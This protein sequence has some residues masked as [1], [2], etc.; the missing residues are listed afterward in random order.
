[1][2]VKYI[3]FDFFDTLAFLSKAVNWDNVFEM[4]PTLYKEK[5]KRIIK[6]NWI[7]L[8]MELQS[9]AEKTHIE[10]SMEDVSKN[11]FQ[12][13]PQYL[14]ED[15]FHITQSYMELW[16]QSIIVYQDVLEIIPKLAQ[17]YQLGIISNTHDSDVVPSIINRYGLAKYFKQIVLSVDETYR[18][19]NK[20]IFQV[21]TG[22]F[23]CP[24]EWCFIGDNFEQDIQ[25]AMA[26]NIFPI[27]ISR[28]ATR[29]RE[30]CITINTLYEIGNVLNIGE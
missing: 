1:M 13:I 23:H 18:K 16:E 6:T 14:E 27:L 9:N 4:T 2:N 19:P 11:L 21:A 29:K 24:Q 22:L 30:K 28:R 15:L 17:E 10:F 8:F 5:D 12:S 20:K 7:S 25:G 26:A 3:Y